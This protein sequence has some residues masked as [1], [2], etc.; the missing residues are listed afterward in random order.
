M[1]LAE[2]TRASLAVAEA[3]RPS[4]SRLEV[5][6]SI[7]RQKTNPKD[8]ELV[9]IVQD[10]DRLFRDLACAGQF[11]KPSVPDIVPWDPKP[12]A[13]YLRMLLSEGV[14]LDLFVGTPDNWGALL[15]MRTGSA[16][17]PEGQYGFVP[18]MFAAWKRRSGGGRM[19]GCLPTMPDGT[20]VA[21]PEEADFFRVCGVRWVEPCDRHSARDAKSA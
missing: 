2:A 6:G 3:A 9:A 17:G 13:K 16:A 4:C 18:A 21:V 1:D 19:L 5:A 15:A 14:K 8:I 12:G 10:Y 7:R 20:S 11:I